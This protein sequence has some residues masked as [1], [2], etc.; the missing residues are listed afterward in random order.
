LVGAQGLIRRHLA[1]AVGDHTAQV[2]VALFL[3]IGSRQIGGLHGFL[4]LAIGPMTT[5]ALGFEGGFASS[6][7]SLGRCAQQTNP[8]Q[9]RRSKRQPTQLL[10]FVLHFALL[11]NF[12]GDPSSSPRRLSKAEAN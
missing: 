8:S 9:Q 11:T 1:L 3:N 4:A 7:I 6:D 5:G 2:G 12:G 10:Y